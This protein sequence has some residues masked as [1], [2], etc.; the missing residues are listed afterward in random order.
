MIRI[1]E[2]GIF[3]DD[4]VTRGNY[5]EEFKEIKQ[6]LVQLLKIG[7]FTLHKWNLNG[8]ELE[9]ESSNQKETNKMIHY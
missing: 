7:H 3:V 8:H 6:N 4:L 2:N 1:I 5:L 9:R